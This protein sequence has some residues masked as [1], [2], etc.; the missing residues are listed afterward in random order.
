MARTTATKMASPADIEKADALFIEAESKTPADH[1]DL[2]AFVKDLYGKTPDDPQVAWRMMRACKDMAGM[3]K[4][5]NAD[6]KKYAYEGK[7]IALKAV[8]GPGKDVWQVQM[9]TGALF[10]TCS[11]FEMMNK[12]ASAGKMKE[13]FEA[14]AK[15]A[16][17]I[18]EPLH[19]LG[20]AEFGFAD[21]GMAASMMGLKGTYANALELFNKAEALCPHDCYKREGGHYK[22]NWLMLV[23]ANK[24]TKNK[25]EAKVWLDKLLAAEPVTPDDRKALEEAKKIKI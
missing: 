17:D 12:L 25:A 3:E 15:L 9:F 8:E 5:S 6:K 14:A 18:P 21:A 7:D 20:Q 4:L 23:K 22:T 16:P 1:S 10:G 11:N 2:Y 13:Y 24:A 19:S